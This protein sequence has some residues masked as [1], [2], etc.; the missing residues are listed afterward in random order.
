MV[1]FKVEILNIFYLFFCAAIDAETARQEKEASEEHL[2]ELFKEKLYY[3]EFNFRILS[4]QD[5]YNGQ[6]RIKHSIMG[7][8]NVDYKKEITSNIST[9]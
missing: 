3:N 9:I 4:K 2:K 1:G 8:E 7:V 5:A 6:T